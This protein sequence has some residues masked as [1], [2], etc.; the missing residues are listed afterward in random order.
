MSGT[1]NKAIAPVPTAQ[2]F[3]DVILS[4]TQR[5][6]PTVIRSGFKISRIRA[7][8]MRKVKFTQAS[9]EER[10]DQILTE[11]PVM[12]N[13]HPFLSSLLN[14]LYDKN[15]YKL[16]LGQINTARHLIVQVGKDYCRLIKFGDS[17]YRCKQLKKAALGRMATI[18]KRQKDPLAYLEQVRQHMSRLPSIDP[19]TRTLLICGY[20]NVG[21]SSFVNKVTRADVDVQPYAFTTKSLFVGHMDYKYLR[22]QVIDTPGVLDHPLEEMN[23]IEMQSIT[24]L[25]H[26]RACVMYFMDLSEQCGFTVEAQC[27]LYQSIKPLFANKP[28]FIVINKIDIVRPEDLDPERKAMLDAI[29]AEDGVE[30]LALSCVSDEGVMDVRNS[31]CDA[32]L[33]HR[34]E[35]KEKT[36]RVENIANRVR[37]AV[38]VPRDG[39]ERKAFIPE[40]VKNRKTYDREDPMRRRI[41]RDL[42]EENGGAGVYSSDLKKNYKL[43]NDE[44]KYDVIPEI[45]DGKNIAD[46]IDPDIVAKL[47]ELEAE[48]E[49]LEAAGFYDSESEVDSEEETIRTAASTIRDKK[50]LFRLKNQEKNKQ[51]NR[52][53]VPRKD[54]ERTLSQMTAMLKES[55]YDPSTLEERATVLAKARGLVGRKRGAN[56]D[57]EMDEDG[58]EPVFGSEDDDEDGMDVEGDGARQASKKRRT[59]STSAVAAR[60]GSGS[61][62]PRGKRVPKTNRATANLGGAEQED[63]VKELRTLAQRG[64]NSKAR[65]G[66]GDRHETAAIPKWLFSGKRGGGKTNRR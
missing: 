27:K 26:L 29:L 28:T 59:S 42:E 45:Q 22:W 43:K 54:Q 56:D 37:V 47:D 51:Q 2:E 66:E 57:D 14:V 63:K 40:A 62:V 34:V 32:L 30:L 64:P 6:T 13:L 19:T 44:W 4:K 53:M 39:V 10:L 33:A 11:F 16:A 5:K 25:A 35:S 61:I 60:S 17:L 58:E 15:H 3:L 38:P 48:E 8:Y 1:I 20:P 24:A 46:F 18:M 21:K 50:A 36:R 7:F 49:R 52:S 9:F 65:A 41:E 55:G 31:A 12:D 23:T